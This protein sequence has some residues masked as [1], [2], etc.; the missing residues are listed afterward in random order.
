M[1]SAVSTRFDHVIID[2]PASTS[3]E[4]LLLTA[5]ANGVIHVVE[6][7]DDSIEASRQVAVSVE[8]LPGSPP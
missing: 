5:A 7:N 3:P 4:H 8:R 2:T 1:I 6:P